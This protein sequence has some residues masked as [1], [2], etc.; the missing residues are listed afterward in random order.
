MASLYFWQFYQQLIEKC[1]LAKIS[2]VNLHTSHVIG[3]GGGKAFNAASGPDAF[4][5]VAP[6]S[7]V[8]DAPYVPAAAI[9]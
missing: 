5:I 9:W 3:N 1:L 6:V 8:H 4:V 7:I 2:L